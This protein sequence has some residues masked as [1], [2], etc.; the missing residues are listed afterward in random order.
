MGDVCVADWGII[1]LAVVGLVG[2]TDTGLDQGDHIGGGIVRIGAHVGADEATNASAH[3]ETHGLGQ[4]V[5]ARACLNE[6]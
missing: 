4:F 6:F 5:A 1:L 2:Q 3:E